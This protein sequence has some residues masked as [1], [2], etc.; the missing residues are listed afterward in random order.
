MS[1]Q[2]PPET[3]LKDVRKTKTA[4]ENGKVEEEKGIH[5]DK[6]LSRPNSIQDQEIKDNLDIANEELPKLNTFG[7]GVDT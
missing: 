7:I 2:S 3:I 5:V 1:I 6:K 4:K